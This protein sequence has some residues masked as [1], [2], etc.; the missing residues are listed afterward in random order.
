MNILF[1]SYQNVI[2]FSHNFLLSFL[3]LKH[4]SAE[5]SIHLTC[6]ISKAAIKSTHTWH[7]YLHTNRKW[8]A[9]VKDTYDYLID[10]Q[11]TK[12]KWI[13]KVITGLDSLFWARQCGDLVL[14][15]LWSFH[16]YLLPSHPSPQFSHITWDGVS[17]EK[18]PCERGRLTHLL[19]DNQWLF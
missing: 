19:H 6:I 4:F 16:G 10:V 3:P 13:L 14:L 12:L 17:D 9:I 15:Y 11:S 7:V 8:T 1:F 18:S 2:I 5:L